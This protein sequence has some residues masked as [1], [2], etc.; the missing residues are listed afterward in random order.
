MARRKKRRSK[1]AAGDALIRILGENAGEKLL[2]S[3]AER[4]GCGCLREDT[5]NDEAVAMAL[6]Y[7]AIDGNVTAA[8]YII[9][10]AE[11]KREEEEKRET[12]E[13]QAVK[14]EIT[15]ADSS[16]DV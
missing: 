14:I 4:T 16:D 10:A 6:I 12:G 7:E 3:L 5:T 15:V 11:K 8:K 2:T 1:P 9:D 13:A